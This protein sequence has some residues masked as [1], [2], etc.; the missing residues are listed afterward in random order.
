MADILPPFPV[1]SEANSYTRID[2]YLKLRTLLN[3]V[4]SVAWAV[5]DKAGSNL[6]DIQ[7]RNHNDLQN[8]QGGVVGERNHLSN[9]ELAEATNTRSSRGIDTTDD[10][11]IDLATKGLVLKDTQGTP[12]YWRVTISTLGVLTT[13]DLGTTKP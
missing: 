13:T 9:A 3:S 11:I 10:L 2:W 8:I 4:N 12:H 5:I 7:T 1:D 6:T